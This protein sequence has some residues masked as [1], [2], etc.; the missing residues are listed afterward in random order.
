MEAAGRHVAREVLKQEVVITHTIRG[1]AYQYLPPDARWNINLRVCV[2]PKGYTF[3][4]FPKRIRTQFNANG[5][6]K[7]VVPFMQIYTNAMR[8]SR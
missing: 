4:R 1:A 8:Q 2:C 6:V 3:V 7:V 5:T